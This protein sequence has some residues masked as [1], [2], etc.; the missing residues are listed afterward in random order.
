MLLL[1]ALPSSSGFHYQR[2]LEHRHGTGTPVM[3]LL[4]NKKI[5]LRKCGTSQAIR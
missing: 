2:H 1:S 5:Y 3:S 4:T